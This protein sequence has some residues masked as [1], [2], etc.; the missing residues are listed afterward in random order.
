MGAFT[1]RRAFIVTP[2]RPL[3]KRFVLPGAPERARWAGRSGAPPS[4]GQLAPPR[5]CKGSQERAFKSGVGGRGGKVLICSRAVPKNKNHTKTLVS[6][7][8]RFGLLRG[9]GSRDFAP[10][11][12]RW[13][14]HR[15]VRRLWVSDLPHG[16]PVH[17]R[18][19]VHCRKPSGR[20]GWAGE[21]R[22]G[23]SKGA[24]TLGE[25]PA[26]EKFRLGPHL[27]RSRPNR[28]TGGTPSRSRYSFVRRA[29]SVPEK[30]RNSATDA[31]AESHQGQQRGV[32]PI[33]PR[34]RLSAAADSPGRRPA[35]PPARAGGRRLPG[36]ASLSPRPARP[37]PRVSSPPLFPLAK[38]RSAVLHLC[39]S[40]VTTEV[41]H[42]VTPAQSVSVL[43]PRRAR[44]HPRQAARR[45]YGRGEDGPVRPLRA[46]G[47]GIAPTP[48]LVDPRRPAWPGSR[49]TRRARPEWT[50]A[51]PT[52][53]GRSAPHAPGQGGLPPLTQGRS[54]LTSTRRAPVFTPAGLA[55]IERQT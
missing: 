55:F 8:R 22:T 52:R 49:D 16:S 5:V 54:G 14:H 9:R 12:C 36:S 18:H 43:T 40:V 10:E 11:F 32:Q 30:D 51:T 23:K 17:V 29:A 45:A 20:G 42:V 27:E 15:R 7:Y 24:Q 1:Q 28:G 44:P 46:G 3:H 13:L 50:E 41:L 53:R 35:R 33:S 38:E 6:W 37:A 31:V 19:P 2:V 21:A 39:P 4:K 47:A 26:K 48:G 25:G 34:A